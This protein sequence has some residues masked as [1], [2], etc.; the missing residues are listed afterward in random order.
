MQGAGRAGRH[1]QP[2]ATKLGLALPGHWP[3]QH[4]PGRPPS[5]PLPPPPGAAWPPATW[6]A[7]AAPI[8]C[9]ACRPGWTSCL[10]CCPYP[11]PC[12]RRC[13]GSAVGGHG[14]AT[15]ISQFGI[16]P[17]RAASTVPAGCTARC[18]PAPD[19]RNSCPPPTPARAAPP[20][21]APDAYMVVVL[22]LVAVA[23]A[24][25]V[26]VPPLAMAAAVMV[27]FPLPASLPLSV[28][29][30]RAR[31]GARNGVPCSL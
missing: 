4:L 1:A 16:P 18:T 19:V 8:A 13:H 15:G 22:V 7:R 5:V 27:P 28:S 9:P 30:K 6:S 17:G 10:G 2:V 12:R 3:R 14:A 31:H 23:A 11:C 21:S 25:P 26:Y 20:S 24:M 29:C